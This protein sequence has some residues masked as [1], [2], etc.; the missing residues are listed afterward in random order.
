MIQ[1][2]KFPVTV[3]LITGTLVGVLSNKYKVILDERIATCDE[4]YLKKGEVYKG[5]IVDV[6]LTF[7]LEE[8]EKLLIVGDMTSKVNIDTPLFVQIT[9]SQLLMGSWQQR[10]T[11]TLFDV[12]HDAFNPVDIYYRYFEDKKRCPLSPGVSCYKNKKTV[13]LNY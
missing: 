13:F 6:N 5:R 11:K 2:L 9:A 10:V 12:C 7:V 3:L 8:D 4:K 1:I